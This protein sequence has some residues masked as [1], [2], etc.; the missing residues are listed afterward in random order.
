V[1]AI[2]TSTPDSSLDAARW[3]T[4]SR[5]MS[6]WCRT[7]PRDCRFVGKR[8][9]GAWPLVGAVIRRAG[10]LTV[11]RANLS[12]SVEDAERVST[13]IR[14]G[15]SLVFCPEGTVPEGPCLLPFL[16]GEFKAAEAAGCP[17]VP[18]AIRGTRAILPAGAWLPR[19]G[20]ITVTI[21][22]PIAARQ[23]DWREIVGLRDAVRV[24]INRGV[25]ELAA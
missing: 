7:I 12:R 10:H 15:A 21:G 16:P 14:S 8:E 18:V 4:T 3:D 22:A 2:L 6:S 13:A 11:E 23:S 5:E 20:P 19:P 1:K 24:A 9:L 25:G 17:V